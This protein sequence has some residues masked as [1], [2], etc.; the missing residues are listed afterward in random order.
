MVITTI[1]IWLAVFSCLPLSYLLA[2]S[3]ASGYFAAKARFVDAI[4]KKHNLMMMM[5]QAVNKESKNG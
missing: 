4:T 5:E 1:I 2:Y 3:L